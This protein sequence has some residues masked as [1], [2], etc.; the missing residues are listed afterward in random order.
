VAVRLG[1]KF[2]FSLTGPFLQRDINLFV[3][4]IERHMVRMARYQVFVPAGQQLPQHKRYLLKVMD[5]VICETPRE[6]EIFS[7]GEWRVLVA[8]RDKLPEI[9]EGLVL[10]ETD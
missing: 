4:R 10:G 5:F 3:G 6:Q 7:G 9:L 8:T 1:R 2:I